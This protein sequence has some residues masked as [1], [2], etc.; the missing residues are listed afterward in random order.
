M[1]LLRFSATSTPFGRYEIV[2]KSV[3]SPRTAST[4]CVPSARLIS[5][6]VG[7]S[8]V[9]AVAPPWPVAPTALPPFARRPPARSC[10]AGGHDV[11]AQGG[12]RRERDDVAKE[13]AE[14]GVE[15]VVAHAVRREA[16]EVHELDRRRVAEEVRDRRSRAD[17][18][19]AGHRE[20]GP[21]C[22]RP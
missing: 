12:E 3:W 8:K 15:V 9:P 6:P 10:R 17:G 1:P 7:L 5:G 21:P 13:V 18:V 20:D 16:H 4:P 19:A 22:L 2:W 14:T 11:G